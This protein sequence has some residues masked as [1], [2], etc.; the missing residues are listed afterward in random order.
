[1]K[2]RKR[3]SF[4]TIRIIPP[5]NWREKRETRSFYQKPFDPCI[6]GP[7]FMPVSCVD[8]W[9]L[10]TLLITFQSAQGRKGMESQKGETIPRHQ[11]RMKLRQL[12]EHNGKKLYCLSDFT[13]LSC[14]ISLATG[15]V[16]SSIMAG[17]KD[18]KQPVKHL[19]IFLLQLQKGQT[20]H[21]HPTTMNFITPIMC[22]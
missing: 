15:R 13:P 17:I 3:Q 19:S 11:V 6:H 16:K 2:N 8:N 4:I 7:D 20:A 22:Y 18:Q 9:P 12:W 21:F 10:Q 14:Y 5:P 1:M